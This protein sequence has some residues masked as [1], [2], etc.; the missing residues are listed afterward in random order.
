MT[1]STTLALDADFGYVR[2]AEEQRRFDDAA[3]SLCESDG[4]LNPAT[5]R[6]ELRADLVLEGCGVKAPGLVGAVMA[7][8]EAGYSFRAVAGTS[9]GAVTASM[10]AGLSQSG[11]PLKNLLRFGLTLD[12]KKFM[13]NGKTHELFERA[14]GRVGTMLADAALLSERTGLYSGDYL[15]EWLGPILHEQL[16]ISTFADL[17]ISE[18]DDPD[19]SLA[20]GRNYRLVVLTSDITRGQL[21]RLPW[22]YPLYGHDPD[23]Q[24]PVDAVRASMSIPFVFEPVHFTSREATVQVPGPGGVTTTVHYGAGTHT[25][26][27]GALLEKFPIHAFDRVDGRA[28]RWP[29]IGVKLSRLETEVP[30]RPPCDSA[31]AVA[32]HCLR[33]AMNEWDA[34]ALHE[35]TAARTIFVD[36]AGLATTDF[37]VP[38]DRQYELFLNGVRAASDFVIASAAAGGV[39][40]T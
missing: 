17:K 21:A 27:D 14:T 7:L 34:N 5:G 35:R 9:A 6:K 30:A 22:D 19:M 32:M 3:Q 26:V 31:L 13:P 39:P 28:P 36:N 20:P 1:D 37:D 29:T 16:G 15:A 10:V 2:N 38:K 12:F 33:T 8:G 25:W 40:R 23:G 11:L 24:D 18:A 4:W